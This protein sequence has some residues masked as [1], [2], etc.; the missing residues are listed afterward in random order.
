MK[1]ATSPF[2]LLNA[3]AGG[4][5]DLSCLEFDYGSHTITEKNAKKLDSL[6][7]ALYERPALKL[8]IEGHVDMEKDREGLRKNLFNKKLKSQKLKEM[9]KK[10]LPAV[11]VDEVRIEADEY[12]TFLK[13]AYKAEKFPKPRNAAG[14][15]KK[16]PPTEMEKL[17]LTN[18]EIKNDDL[19][20]LA[21]KRAEGVKSL[22]LKSKKIEP[23]R[24]FLVEPKSLSPEKKEKLKESRVDFKLK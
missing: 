22:I 18:I 1:A 20:L 16:L 12:Q 23:G 21:Y 3:I 11:S 9:L 4:E 17:L 2:A 6:I 13:M 19:R 5:D 7:K 24:L 8:D 14:L 15:E 10:G